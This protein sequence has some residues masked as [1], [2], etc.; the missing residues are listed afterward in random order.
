LS[1][2]PQN[3]QNLISVTT[4]QPPPQ[5][6]LIFHVS[7]SPSG[8]N[9][10]FGLIAAG[11]I[12]PPPAIACTRPASSA[13]LSQQCFIITHHH[14]RAEKVKVAQAEKQDRPIFQNML[15]QKFAEHIIKVVN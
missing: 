13:N 10:A 12:S 9:W 8:S 15:R 5:H 6:P 11:Y 7:P 14:Q 3:G 1:L 2:A 4:K